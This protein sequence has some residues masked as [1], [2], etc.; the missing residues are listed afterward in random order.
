MHAHLNLEE[1]GHLPDKIEQNIFSEG[2]KEYFRLPCGYFTG[3]CSIYDQ[4][5][6]DVCSS[7]RCQILKDF[8]EGK[9]TQDDAAAIVKD[10]KALRMHL[11]EQYLHLSENTNLIC[12]RHLL[13]EL[14]KKQSSA[15]D[16][17]PMNTEYEILLARCN[18]FEAL[19]IKNFRSEQDF[20][21][22]K[23]ETE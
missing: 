5:R 4:K 23:E 7:Y 6:A 14:G 11:L 10:A 1:K 15:S 13:I 22:M 16:G 8:S 3:K 17:D 18:I 20:D 12:F 9:I 19:L 21:K 2:G